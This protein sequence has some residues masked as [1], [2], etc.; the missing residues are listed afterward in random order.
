MNV[1]VKEFKIKIDGKEYTF[2][3]DFKALL[4]FTNRYENALDIFNDFLQGKNAYDCMIKILSCA[5]V[6]REFAE[7]ELAKN[8]PFS[9]STMKL[10]DGITFALIEGVLQEKDDEEVKN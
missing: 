6:E 1:E 7:D 4:K 5:C 10:F 9:F 8:I 3:L 2:R